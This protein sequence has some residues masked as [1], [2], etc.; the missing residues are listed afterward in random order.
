MLIGI[1]V[2]SL[3]AIGSVMKVR[4]ESGETYPF[5]SSLRADPLGTRAL[6][7]ALGRQPGV[8]VERNFMPL[9]R[10]TAGGKTTLVLSGINARAFNSPYWLDTLA[11]SRFALDGGRVVIALNPEGYDGRMERV[12]R[13]SVQEVEEEEHKKEPKDKKES[14]D[15]KDADKKAPEKK[16]PEKKSPK[17]EKKEDKKSAKK[18]KA[19]EQEKKPS[20]AEVLRIAPKAVEW[21]HSRNVEGS[22]LEPR[23]SSTL[24]AEDYPNWM[25]NVFLNDDPKLN[26]KAGADE[27][28]RYIEKKT[29]GDA[30]KMEAKPEVKTDV[31]PS[32]W[33]MIAGKSER[34]M[35]AERKFGAG[36]VVVCTDRYF[37][38]NEALWKDPKPVFLSWLIGDATKVIFEET[39]LGSEIGDE[40]GIM[41]LAK[42]HGMHGLFLG[43]L[44]LFAL[45]VWRSAVSLVPSNADDDMGHW[46]AD[47]V[48]GRSTASGLEGLLRRGIGSKGLLKRCFEIWS[49][50][51]VAV[52][53]LP[54]ER[55]QAAAK[56]VEANAG[57][58]NAVTT[59][60]AV[61]DALHPPR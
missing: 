14:K 54:A 37:L 10:L 25:S 34:G 40:E 52:A 50:T 36:S 48:E 46:R 23:A 21:F 43:G 58:K 30:V 29:Q 15:A 17:P 9:D 53:A 27:L 18:A 1:G 49:G 8:K 45:F 33:T 51:R 26:W 60:R 56:I 2:V 13:E 5:Y 44:L 31:Q 20:F 39:H 38:S 16:V 28:S 4:V 57:T 19:K 3:V 35:I 6:Y 32:P 61:R 47:A 12:I 22:K 55:V 59:Y 11:V 41:T 42:R 7:E 24:K